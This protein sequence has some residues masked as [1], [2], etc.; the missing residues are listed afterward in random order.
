MSD[1]EVEGKLE[2]DADELVEN[3]EISS[4]EAGFLAGYNEAS[5]DAE[6]EVDDVEEEVE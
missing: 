1:E 3:D 6:D 5:E 2:G 4:E